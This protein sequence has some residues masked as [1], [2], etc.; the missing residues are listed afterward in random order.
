MALPGGT[1]LGSNCDREPRPSSG[2]GHELAVAQ[3]SKSRRRVFVAH[4]QHLDHHGVDRSSRL[5]NFNGSLSAAWTVMQAAGVMWVA[6]A[7]ARTLGIH[8]VDHGAEQVR[9]NGADHGILRREAAA[10]D[11]LDPGGAAVGDLDARPSA[12]AMTSPPWS[13]IQAMRASV[14][15]PAPPRATPNPQ[16]SRK[17]RKHVNADG[18]GLLIGR[19]Q[20]LAGDARE[21]HPHL[22]VLEQIA[23]QIVTA[24]LHDPP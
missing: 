1:R 6:S 3:S 24:H 5:R 2:V 16:L 20:V 8:A 10:V 18:G 13:R 14:N 23:E 15:L 7:S 9:M 21:M 4:R 11:R 19:D 22:F 17:P 12:F